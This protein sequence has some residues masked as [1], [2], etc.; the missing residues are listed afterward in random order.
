MSDLSNPKS[1]LLYALLACSLA[2]NVVMLLNRTPSDEANEAPAVSA[3]IETAPAGTGAVTAAAAPDSAEDAAAQPAAAQPEPDS[4]PIA[5]WAILHA[6]VEQ[7]LARTF[8][9]AAGE[10]GDALASVFTRLFVWDL[11]LR[12]D[13]QAG[14]SVAVVWRK[15]ADGLP[16][17]AAG[18]LQSKRLGRTLT[19][20]RWQAPDDRFPSFWHLDGTEAPLRLRDSPIENYEQITS[21]LK[22]RPTHKGMD[23][24]TPVGTEVSAPLAGTVTRANW[25]WSANGN[26]VEIRYDDGVIAKFLH[27]SENRVAEGQRVSAGQLIAL[28][29]NTGHTTAPHLHYQLDRNDKTVD[30][31]EY[32]GTLRR[33]LKADQI[34]ALQRDVAD[35]ERALDAP[36]G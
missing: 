11:D 7:S 18:S 31:L 17:I 10:D 30:P 5:G 21:L 36:A 3:E 27:L 9:L 12:R 29:G 24:K 1:W 20:Y 6:K 2:L 35:F 19:A 28:S 13:M 4:S 23:F 25:N 26:C 22:D 32:H 8:Q 33:A 15:G 16:E 34:A 14:D